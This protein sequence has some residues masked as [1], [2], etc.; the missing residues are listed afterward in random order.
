MEKYLDVKEGD[1]IEHISSGDYGGLKIKVIEK[2]IESDRIIAKCEVIE[3]DF[4]HYPI[5]YICTF[6]MLEDDWKFSSIKDTTFDVGNL[7][8]YISET[9]SM[10]KSLVLEV[11]SVNENNTFVGKVIKPSNSRSDTTN[12]IGSEVTLNKRLFKSF[13]NN[14]KFTKGDII[15]LISDTE[16]LLLLVLDQDT[17]SGL[18]AVIKSSKKQEIGT[19]KPFNNQDYELTV[20]EINTK[21][22]N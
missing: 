9:N 22:R 8:T 5:G 18:G 6:H 15:S 11:I 21:L 14:I 4:R 3:K 16:I 19:L 20:L 17:M 10:Y 1:I 2:A 13:I 7:V 12:I